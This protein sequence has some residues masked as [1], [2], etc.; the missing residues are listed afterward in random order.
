[1]HLAAFARVVGVEGS[2]V[3]SA[4]ILGRRCRIVG[5]AFVSCKGAFGKDRG[6]GCMPDESFCL[7]TAAGCVGLLINGRGCLPPVQ[8]RLSHIARKLLMMFE[9]NPTA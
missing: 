8:N 2:F 4:E 7:Y 9:W 5:I 1:M 6:I 3:G